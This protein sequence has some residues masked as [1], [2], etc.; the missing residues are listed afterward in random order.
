M[1]SAQRVVPDL[2]EAA[3][4]VREFTAFA[5]ARGWGDGLPCIPPTPA[6]V[7]EYLASST[8]R[9]DDVVALL[10]PLGAACSVEHV[11]VNAAMAGAPPAALP[12]LC[13]AVEAM[14]ADDFNLAGINATT[15]P[16]VPMVIVNGDQRERL[17]IA[18][19]AG[20]LGGAVSSSVAIGRALRLI[21]RNVAGQRIDTTS[22]STF[23]QP[24]RITGLVVA[25]REDMSPWPP[26]AERRGV[27]G[28]AVTVFGTMGTANILD[29]VAADP[30]AVVEMIGRSIAYIGANNFSAAQ[31]STP[32]ET[33]I[34]I[35]PIW[36]TEVLGPAYPSMADVQRAIWEQAVVPIDWFPAVYRPALDEVG[37]VGADGLVHLVNS[38]DDLIVFVCGG[39]GA[40]HATM[41]HGFGH[42]LAVTVPVG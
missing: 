19:G 30:G 40:L 39:T 5:E 37:R 12:L 24:A 31:A 32:G 26:L 33:A 6:L 8:R 16:V 17:G 20:C 22:E 21:V 36:A 35:N 28:D 23:G 34:A 18:S 41:F 1:P 3:L 42:T 10:L 29:I 11:A 25:E 14:A 4:D 7:A 27:P 38:P 15:A 9:P 13:A 2:V